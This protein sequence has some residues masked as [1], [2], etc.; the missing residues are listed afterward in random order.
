MNN[1]P[2]VGITIV[3][4]PCNKKLFE[5][6]TIGAIYHLAEATNIVTDIFKSDLRIHCNGNRNRLRL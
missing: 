6:Q 4:G 5:Q 3:A 1:D 2:A